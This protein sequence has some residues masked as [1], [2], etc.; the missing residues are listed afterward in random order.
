MGREGDL[1]VLLTMQ[2]L[3]YL[4]YLLSYWSLEIHFLAHVSNSK[5]RLCGIYEAVQKTGQFSSLW[6]QG[7]P[8]LLLLPSPLKLDVPMWVAQANSVVSEEEPW[9]ASMVFHVPL[10]LPNDHGASTS[11]GSC[12]GMNCTPLKIHMLEVLSPGASKWSCI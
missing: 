2:Q 4:F 3:P 10:S 5:I 12:Y 9:R 7:S 6:E 11:L 8:A 1:T